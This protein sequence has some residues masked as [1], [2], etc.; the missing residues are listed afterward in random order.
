MATP[1]PR[2]RLIAAGI[3]LLLAFGAAFASRPAATARDELTIG[4]T[5]FPATF[6]PNID[7]MLAKS[8]IL[9]MTR[10]PL[11]VYDKDW[12]LVCLLCTELPT[13]EN[14]LAKTIDLPEGKQ[15]I[16]VTYTIQPGATWGDG[17]P[18]TTDDV[19]FTWEVGR[20]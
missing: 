6:H 7:S 4:I 9:A 5:Q 2:R 17:V 10:R 12:K 15:G 19:L 20:H 18:V 8:Y 16:A 13:I 14:G 11:T 1:M 3:V